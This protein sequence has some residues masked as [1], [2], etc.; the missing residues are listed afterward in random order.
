MRVSPYLTYSRPAPGEGGAN[1]KVYAY[2]TLNP[3]LL[4]GGTPAYVSETLNLCAA[5]EDT[6]ILLPG[7][8]VNLGGATPIFGP[9]SDFTPGP[10]VYIHPDAGTII[11]GMAAL[12]RKH[13]CQVK[14][15]GRYLYIDGGAIGF[16][17]DYSISTGVDQSKQNRSLYIL[18]TTG[19]VYVE[20]L[21]FLGGDF[22]YEVCN[23]HTANTCKVYFQNWYGKSKV[24]SSG[25][26]MGVRL[27]NKAHT[28]ATQVNVS[29]INVQQIG[30]KAVLKMINKKTIKITCLKNWIP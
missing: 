8:G 20:G 26:A 12:D 15:P 1:V 24:D 27:A 18:N 21:A 22:E 6:I 9:A 3:Y 28:S 29:K 30:P 10:N 7:R 2:R 5:G 4:S 17:Q 23:L 14:A 16:T 11:D 19:A 25:K 13:G